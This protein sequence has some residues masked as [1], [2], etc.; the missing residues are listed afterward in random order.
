METGNF[1]LQADVSVVSIS[2]TI[3]RDIDSY[4]YNHKYANLLGFKLNFI[5]AMSAH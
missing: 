3:I 2:K 5:R 4:I 1:F